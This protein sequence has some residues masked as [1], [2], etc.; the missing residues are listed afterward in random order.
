[1]NS[2]QTLEPITLEGGIIR[3][4][5]LS[6]AHYEGLCL[7]GLEPAI[8]QWVHTP[9]T[10]PEGM[11]AYID[12]A[13]QCHQ[14]GTTLPF[15][16]ID[17]A[18]GIPIGSTRFTGFSAAH[19]QLEIGW[20]WICIPWQGSLVNTEMKYLMLRQAFEQWGCIR[21]QFKTDSLNIRSQR[22]LLKIG[23]HEEGT[24]RNHMK[25][26]TGRI[27]H[28]VYYSILDSEWP[29]IKAKLETRLLAQRV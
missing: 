17:Q 19:S 13:I 21:V 9:A 16:I 1:M 8:W 24:F 26:K 15:A 6:M 22:A 29:D 28:S 3:L 20:T 10:S 25:L 27:R 12:Y 2:P 7:N 4:E 14:E 23:A 11:K 18:T 5:P